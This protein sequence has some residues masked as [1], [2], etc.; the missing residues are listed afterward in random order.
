MGERMRH[1]ILGMGGV[2]GLIGAVLAHA[3]DDVTAVVRAPALAQYPPRLSLESRFGAF[4]VPVPAVAVVNEP[5]DVLWVAVKA[6]QLEAALAAVQRPEML[7]AVVP[8]L[9][10]V[11]H[12]A[13]LRSRFGHERVVPATISVESER[14][15]PGRI[16]HRSP[17]ADLQVSAIGEARLAP[18]VQKLH[19]FGFGTRFVEDEA[20]LL[21][22]KLVFLAPLALTTSAAMK[23]I[24]EVVSDPPWRARLERC[25]AEACAVAVAS[26]A[27]VDATR[28]VQML[29]G[30][31]A[32]L[33]SSMLKDVAAGQ[34]P[35][36]DA[37][38]GPIVDAGPRHDIDVSVT[39]E[40]AEMVRARVA[41]RSTA[42]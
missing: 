40:L 5:F 27:R 32:A 28:T 16:V 31:P 35:E 36:L 30:L 39:R 9:N 24:G 6:T 3:G 1:A 22:S 29:L 25:A 42:P 7:G 4:S 18:A 23:A 2:G 11:D 34:P 14:T 38:A 17:F 10:G 12:V 15:A 19:E 37:I 41:E 26:G 20:T 8:L 13:L 21:W 33:R